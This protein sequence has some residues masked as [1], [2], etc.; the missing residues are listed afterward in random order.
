[1]AGEGSLIEFVEC[2]QQ[3]NNT[4]AYHAI[5]NGLCALKGISETEWTFLPPSNQ[6]ERD[7]KPDDFDKLL[8]TALEQVDSGLREQVFV[9]DQAL[10]LTMDDMRLLPEV[11]Y[12]IDKFNSGDDVCLL[13][14]W[15]SEG[16]EVL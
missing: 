5:G 14:N 13:I 16:H 8:H 9:F 15:V 6:W 2:E 11:Y 12:S 7:V 10:S 3:K 4:C 1:M